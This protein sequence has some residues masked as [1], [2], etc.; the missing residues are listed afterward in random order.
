MYSCKSLHEI[1]YI[2][3]GDYATAVQSCTASS[4]HP[5]DFACDGAFDGSALIGNVWASHGEGAGAWIQAQFDRVYI[6]HSLPTRDFTNEQIWQY[7]VTDSI[8][9]FSFPFIC[10]SFP[11]VKLDV[12][13]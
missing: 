11:N 3:S 9:N 12:N 10:S 2:N 5:G 7:N 1:D 13:G 8:A 6:S 4:E